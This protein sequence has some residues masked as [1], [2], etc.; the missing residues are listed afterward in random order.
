MSKAAFLLIA[1]FLG[2]G[3]AASNIIPSPQGDSNPRD[4]SAQVPTPSFEPTTTSSTEGILSISVTTPRMTSGLTPEARNIFNERMAS[5]TKAMIDLFHKE[6]ADPVMADLREDAPPWVLNMDYRIPTRTGRI[7]SVR[8]DGYQYT[9]GAHG[10]AFMQAYM[11]DLKEGRFLTLNDLFEREVVEDVMDTGG[12]P[13]NQLS[14]HSRYA[15]LDREYV[16]DNREWVMSG[17]EPTPDNFSILYAV[18]EGLIV[19]FSDYQ[20]AAHAAGPQEVLIPWSK[21]RGVKSEYLP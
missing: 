2:A 12:S 10:L 16:K 1:V 4:Q 14:Y 17:T 3:C 21:L 13:I 7:Q 6:F 8:L 20:V 11:F 15:L 18:P 5:N 19:Y 9:G